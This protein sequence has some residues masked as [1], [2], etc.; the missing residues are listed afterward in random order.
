MSKKLLITLLILIATIM[1]APAIISLAVKIN[2]NQVDNVLGWSYNAINALFTALGFLSVAFTL[3]FQMK[4]STEQSIFNMFQVFSS[5]EFQDIK[6]CAFRSLIAA[7]RNKEYAEYLS[8]K[9][10]SIKQ[11]PFP[12][13]AI[14]TLRQID[15]SKEN[16]SKEQVIYAD[17][18]DRLKLDNILNFFRVLAQRE[19][20]KTVISHCDFAYDWWRPMLWLVATIQKQHYESNDEIRAVCKTPLLEKTLNSLDKIYGH[21]QFSHSSEVWK[22]IK[23]HPR[24]IEFGIDQHYEEY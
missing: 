19:S 7:A 9:L 23:S 2:A 5:H 13:S 16:L 1:I 12:E 22:Y 15:A 6:D 21:K 11:L 18:S 3:A 14:T 17:R 10:F 24:L 20:S 4:Q 8:S